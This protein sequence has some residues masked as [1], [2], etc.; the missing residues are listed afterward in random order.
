MHHSRRKSGQGASSAPG[1]E[2]RGAGAHRSQAPPRKSREGRGARS[3]RERDYE[4]DD[5]GRDTFP[6][7]W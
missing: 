7:Y 3:P 5:A 4:W 1:G 2:V 6:Q